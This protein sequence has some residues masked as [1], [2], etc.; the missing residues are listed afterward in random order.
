MMIPHHGF[1]CPS[2][3]TGLANFRRIRL[4]IRKL[5]A[6]V[7]WIDGTFDTAFRGLAY[8]VM[9]DL[10]CDVPGV[11]YCSPCAHISDM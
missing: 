7:L 3:R 9:S 10:S 1:F 2:L 5:F 6:G 4:S 11:D 8:G